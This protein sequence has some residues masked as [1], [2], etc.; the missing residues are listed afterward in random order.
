MNNKTWDSDIVVPDW[1]YTDQETYEKEIETIFHG[2]HW[3]FV[4][5]EVEVP[6]IGDYKRSFVGPTA[7][8]LTRAKD[9][10]L[11]VFEN[12]CSHRGVEFCRKPRGNNKTFV[13][14]LH[15]W[16]FDLKGNLQGLPFKKGLHGKGGMPKDFKMEDHGLKKLKVAS[17]AGLVFASYAEDIE[18]IEDYLGKDMTDF[19]DSVYKGRK[20]RVNGY[21]KHLIKSNWKAYVDNLKDPYHATLLHSYFVVFGLFMAE[22][23]SSIFADKEHG[24]HAITATAKQDE[25]YATIDDDTKKEMPS[26]SDKLVLHDERVMEYIKESDIPWSSF[27]ATIFPGMIINKQM[28]GMSVRQLVPNGPDESY[29]TWTMIGYEEDTDEMIHQRMRQDNFHGPSGII[30]M[31]DVEVLEFMQQGFKRSTTE[32]SIYKL[33]LENTGETD[34]LITEAPLRDMYKYYRKVMGI[35]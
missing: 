6:N 15:Q 7:V 22:N 29:L 35:K 2:K 4:G 10:T 20:L 5:L 11:N 23:K 16:S 18:S 14:P 1:V 9:N 27:V 26:Y 25:S 19:I 3:N 28:N 33:D 21:Q 30:T 8:V 31:E 17:Y 13:C 32:N 34:T 24:R 12:R